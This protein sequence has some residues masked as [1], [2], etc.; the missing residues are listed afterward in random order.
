M[1]F[2][3]RKL[4]RSLTLVN[5]FLRSAAAY[6]AQMDRED[7]ALSVETANEADGHKMYALCMFFTSC[8]F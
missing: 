5:I 6:T 1:K 3:Y 8:S 4:W 7:D 2:I